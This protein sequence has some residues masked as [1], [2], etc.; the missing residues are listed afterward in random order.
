MARLTH[1]DKVL[2][3]ELEHHH[4]ERAHGCVLRHE[5]SHLH[6]EG[7]QHQ[8]EDRGR[9]SESVEAFIF[10]PKGKAVKIIVPKASNPAGQIVGVVMVQKAGPV[11]C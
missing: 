2:D 11:G 4:H 5:R 7:Q 3:V 8:K 10:G 9:W 6:R 1:R